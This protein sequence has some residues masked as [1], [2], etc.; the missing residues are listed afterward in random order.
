M[1]GDYD[2]DGRTDVA[3]YRP[4]TGTWYILK[5][6][7]NFTTWNVYQ[8]GI[9]G[10]VPV[11]GDYDG[12]GRTDVAV[13]RPS[14][15]TWF[16]LKSSTNFTTWIVY[17]WGISG[18]I[19]VPG[20]YDGDGKADVAVYRPSNGTWFILKSSTNF[21]TW[22]V[23]Q[24]GIERGHPGRRATTTAT[25]RPTCGVSPVQRHLVHP[26]VEH[27]LHDVDRLSVGHARRHPGAQ[28][29]LSAIDR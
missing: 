17:Q 6:S 24:W 1:P 26:E 29:S 7:T 20:D 28:A 18:D 25:A 10:D 27:E 4:S 8:W 5:S 9:S 22:S 14:D 12:D 21:T 11:P 15:G 23:Y 19:P 16:I 3:V 13:Y 2:G